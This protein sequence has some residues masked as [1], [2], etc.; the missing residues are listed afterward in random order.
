MKTTMAALLG[1]TLTLTMAACDGGGERLTEEEFVSA[2]NEACTEGN[3]EIQAAADEIGSSGQ[4]P[5]E[6]QLEGFVDSIVDAIQGQIDDIDE[7]N[8]PED[9]EEDVDALVAELQ[10]SLDALEEQGAE[11][12]RSEENP[13]TDANEIAGDLG[14][15]VCAEG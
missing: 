6:D 13:F 11:A 7:L 15:T 1:M 14:L 2:A 9:M 10:S 8:P 4:Q 3:E 5:T 12:L